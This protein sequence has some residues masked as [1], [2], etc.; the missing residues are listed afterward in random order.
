MVLFIAGK[1]KKNRKKT[2]FRLLLIYFC[3]SAF[4]YSQRYNFRSISINDGL[5]ESSVNC[6]Q[7]DPKGRILFGTYAGINIYDGES[8]EYITLSEGLPGNYI[9]ILN[10][11]RNGNLLAGTN[12]GLAVFE[13]NKRTAFTTNEGLPSNNVYSVCQIDTSGFMLGTTKGICVFQKGQISIPA[14]FDSLKN[15]VIY[16]IVSDSLHNMYFATSKGIFIYDG[17]KLKIFSEKVKN[18]AGYYTLMID[19]KGNLWAGSAESLIKFNK[20]RIVKLWKTSELKIGIINKI[21]QDKQG[22]IWVGGNHGFIEIYSKGKENLNKYI[23]LSDEQIYSIYEDKNEI[24]WIGTDLGVKYFSG[25]QF[26]L[27]DNSSGIKSSVWS[28]ILAP[29][30][31]ILAGT[32]GTGLLKIDNNRFLNFKVEGLKSSSCWELYY[33]EGKYYFGEGDGFSIYDGENIQKYNS[34]NGFVDDAVYEIFKDSKNNLWLGTSINGLFCFDGKSFQHFSIKEGLSD[35]CIYKIVED[36]NGDIWVGTERGLNRIVNKKVKPFSHQDELNKLTIMSIEKADKNSLWLGTYEKG[37]VKFNTGKSSGEEPFKFITKDEG[38][39]DNAVMFIRKNKNGILYIGTNS[40]I[41]KFDEKEYLKNGSIHIES[42]NKYDGIPGLECNHESAVID[43]KGNLWYGTVGGIVKYIPAEDNAIGSPPKTYIKNLKVFFDKIDLNQ[44]GKFN[45]N[46]PLLPDDLE[47]PY[48]LNH[49]T[50]EFTAINLT[51]PVKVRYKYML[52]GSDK[53]F[54]PPSHR[55]T[56]TYSNLLPGKYCFK[57]LAEDGSG[58]WISEPV[59]YSFTIVAPFWLSKGFYIIIF[60]VIGFITF[61]VTKFRINREIK[62]NT[63]LKAVIKE[64][65]IYE[66]KLLRSEKDLRGIFENAHDPIIIT[67]L[68]NYKILDANKSALDTY[69]YAQDEFIGKHIE[70]ISANINQTKENIRKVAG[71]SLVR[72]FIMQHIKKDGTIIDVE[73]NATVIDYIGTKAILSIERDITERKKLEYNLNKA[74]VEAEKSNKLKSEFLAQM[75]HEIRTP[76][77][78]ILSFVTLLKGE[79][80]DT[81]DEYQQES[82]LLIESGGKRLIRTVD[83][84]LNMSQIQSGNYELHIKELSL[85]EDVLSGICKEFKQIAESKGLVFRIINETERCT[86]LADDYSLNQL[87][88]NLIDNAVKYTQKGYI[89]IKIYLN[90]EDR[91][92]VSVT[93]TGIG[94]HKDYQKNLF[95]PFSQEDSGYTRPYEGNGLGLALVKNYCDMNNAVIEVKSEKNKGSSFIVT[96]NSGR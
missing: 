18:N 75:S 9:Y 21:F 70:I 7:E 81:L 62:R 13:K 96:F 8:F 10:V 39:N 44:Y 58:N 61:I 50:F 68:E 83:S 59:E 78:T 25:K 17:K 57:V 38:L 22:D 31:N 43:T 95:E 33:N 49:I 48:D 60:S 16:S 86:I 12:S 69:G 85:C 23:Y 73:I 88:V 2:V 3:F 26:V 92:A 30:N 4:F 24:L 65:D 46:S 71:E 66:E 67:N 72:N 87:F 35:E 45:P 91:L 20:N 11:D 27:Y 36:N 55:S 34:S 41:N 47:L 14:E 76:V 42:Y 40:G 90:R 5:S 15:R 80:F 56:A 1:N 93:D 51:N 6:I 37:I 64:K 89:E 82:F 53:N 29:D 63:E 52:E 28:L 74:K 32:D 19:S 54:F 84:I 94:I 77:N 79:L